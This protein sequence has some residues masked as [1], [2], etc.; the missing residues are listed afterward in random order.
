MT[1]L[2]RRG[3]GESIRLISWNVAGRVGKLPRQVEGLMDHLPDVVALQEVTATTVPL[4]RSELEDRQYNV[5]TSFD[6]AENHSEL[7]GGRKY[8]V[9][10][11]SRWPVQAL[12]PTE[13]PIPWPER[14]VS[15]IV[16]TPWEEIE[17]HNAHLPAGVAH[18]Y[19]K[20]ETF[21]GIHERLC[22]PTE[23]PRV[24]C[25]D[26]NSPK[27]ERDDDTVVPFG[28]NDRRWSAAELSVIRGLV[29]H[30]LPDVFRLLHGYRKR[31]VSWVMKRKGKLYGRRFDHV[32]ASRR[33]R[34]DA[35]G[36]LHPL[37]ELGLSDHS[38]IDACFD[39]E[40]D[41]I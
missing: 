37:R 29:E 27:S 34:P 32:F 26:F 38:P 39:P 35:C 41:Q 28:G 18:G 20:V 33:L 40:R 9:L 5:M 12:A 6:L 25:G 14:V 15:A 23:R 1:T 36:Y 7:V 22:R 8:G 19:I 10:L 31:E 4:W 13:F 24:L 17:C 2:P 11:A 16:D 30:D 3:V 21:E